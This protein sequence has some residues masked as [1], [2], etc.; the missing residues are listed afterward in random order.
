MTPSR[1]NSRISAAPDEGEVRALLLRVLELATF[2]G[3][4]TRS[5]VPE[6]DSLKHMELVFALEDK[7]GVRFDESEFAKLTSPAAI[8]SLI[9]SKLAP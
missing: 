8:L 2:D 4:L 7:Y 5:E 9:A 1:S 3:E 6:W